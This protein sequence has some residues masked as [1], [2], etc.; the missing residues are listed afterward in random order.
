MVKQTITITWTV[1][2]AHSPK[3][4]T[5]IKSSPAGKTNIGGHGGGN[6]NRCPTCGKYR[7]K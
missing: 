2:R 1:T 4:S 3:G 6:P 7:S 5:V